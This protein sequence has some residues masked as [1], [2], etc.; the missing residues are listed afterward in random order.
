MDRLRPLGRGLR[1]AA[2]TLRLMPSWAWAGAPES[3]LAQ[4]SREALVSLGIQVDLER[5]AEEGGALVVANHLSWVDPLV[6]M[7]MA[8]ALP[9]AKEE[10]GQYPVIGPLAR[11][12]GV[13]FVRRECPQDCGRALRRI[14]T[15]LASGRRV[16]LFPEGTT[17]DGSRLAPLRRG[18]LAA[19]YRLG[20]PLLP[21]RLD[22]PDTAYPW[23]GDDP[24]GPH[25]RTLL[26]RPRTRVTVTPR[27]VLHPADHRT[28]GHWLEAVRW[29]L[30]P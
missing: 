6:I 19:A 14:W 20:L 24:L 5:Q 8:P 22:S 26:D 4:W 21:L 12:A 7:A 30:A 13:R 15:D 16:L 17:T 10:V 18:G 23:L 2:T 27:P 1:L 9:L 28:L 3:V 11:F 25:L 29:A